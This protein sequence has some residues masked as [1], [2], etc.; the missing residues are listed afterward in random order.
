[1]GVRPRRNGAQLLELGKGPVPEHVSPQCR[2]VAMEPSFWSWEKRP[3]PQPPIRVRE[4]AMEP[5]F[6]S[7]EKKEQMNGHSVASTDCRNGAQL[8]E[9][10]KEAR[11]VTWLYSLITVAMEPSFWSWEKNRLLLTSSPAPICRNGAQLLELGK[12]T[13]GTPIRPLTGQS[14]WS[15][16]FG[17]GKS[18]V[19]AQQYRQHPQVAMEPSFWS[20]EKPAP[21]DTPLAPVVSQWSPAFGA[22]KRTL[23]CRGL[24]ILRLSQWSPAFGAGKSRPGWVQ[25]AR[26]SWPVAM[27]PSFWSWEKPRATP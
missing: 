6:W 17:A 19:T 20:W 2:T 14:Q 5:S 9:L 26:V 12:A 13:D 22:G 16:A 8:L 25:R 23:I 1:M 27:E 21:D 18:G 7:W 3:I 4:V 11:L 10:G 15:P 24:L